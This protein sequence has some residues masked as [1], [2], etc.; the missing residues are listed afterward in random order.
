MKDPLTKHL[1]T[2]L[3]ASFP[4]TV[5]DPHC[6]IR[7]GMPEAEYDRLWLARVARRTIETE[8]GCWV[9]Q[10]TVHPK[11]Y[12]LTTYHSASTA[13]HRQAF[14]LLV[15]PDLVTQDFVC[16]RC[17]NPPCWN[18][19]HLWLGDPLTNQ[20]DKNAK[21]RNYFSNQTHCRYGH[22]F[23]PE[24]TYVRAGQPKYGYGPSRACLTCQKIRSSSEEYK[25]KARERQRRQ[26][27]MKNSQVTA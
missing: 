26:R 8:K 7:P 21:R 10:G 17:D 14:K 24:N 27:A 2:E 5:R 12:G 15:K 3:R 19:D 4:D 18:P 22:E 13:V 16:H 6:G 23:T 20:Q 1:L 25:Q 11:G 9:W